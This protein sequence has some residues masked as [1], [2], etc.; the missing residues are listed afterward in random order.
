MDVSSVA[1]TALS[2]AASPLTMG[3][4]ALRKAVEIPAEQS[5]QLIKTAS[6]QVGLGTN[7][8]ITA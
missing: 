7:L 2:A 6:Q 8:D 4:S 3:T 1:S 5:L